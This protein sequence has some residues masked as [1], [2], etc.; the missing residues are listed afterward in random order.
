MMDEQTLQCLCEQEGKPHVDLNISNRREFLNKCG[1]GFGML[2]LA[3]MLNQQK[4]LADDAQPAVYQNPMTPRPGHFAPKAKSVIFLFL[5]G[6]PSGFDLFDYKPEL[7]KNDGKTI[8]QKIETFNANS[9]RLMASPYSFKQYGE[10][11]AWVSEKHPAIAECVDDIAFIKSCYCESNNH[12][13]AMFQMNSGMIRVGFPSVGAWVTYGLGTE[14]QDLPGY[15]V[16]YDHRGG[17]I[18]GPQNWGAGFLPSSYQ[19]TPFRSEGTPILDLQTPL[20]ITR[21]QQRAQLDL[22]AKLNHE[23]YEKHPSEADLIAR[24][25]SYELAYRMQ[26]EA[27]QVMELEEESEAT[28]ELY[29]IN[30]PMTKYVGTQLLLARRMVERGVRFIQVYSG[31]GHQQESWDAHFGLKENHDLHCAETDVPIA[32]L[33][34]DLKQRG[35]LDDTLIVWGGEFG[36]MPLSQGS[37]GRDHNPDGFLMWM[38]G[39]GVKGGTSYGETDE[40]GHK[41]AVNPVSVHDLHATMLHLMGIEHTKL[42]YKH[43][44][45]EYRLT[46]VYGEILH[47][48]LV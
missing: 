5:Y 24:I 34:K 45:R 40:I 25:E 4:L 47:D 29:G 9:G 38:A 17:P 35:L 13:P 39:G 46:D 15:I 6:G 18:G 23:H 19:A 27:P 37:V 2:A 16:M 36:R 31:G 44:G 14:N 22:I 3:D 43:N 30:Q 1:S 8:S 42:T 12:A 48:I 26:M 11:G 32:G 10:S 21:E 28:K 7:Q 20:E 33:L 41:A